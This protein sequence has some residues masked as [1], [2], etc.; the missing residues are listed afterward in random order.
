[1]W[2]PSVKAS[3]PPVEVPR[4]LLAALVAAGAVVSIAT[5]GQLS[6]FSGG[7]AVG[8]GAAFVFSRLRRS[9]PAGD[10]AESLEGRDG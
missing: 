3:V 2:T 7:F 8:A 6:W 10:P 9:D 5:S 1:M 4:L